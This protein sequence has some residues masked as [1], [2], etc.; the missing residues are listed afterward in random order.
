MTEGSRQRPAPRRSPLL[1]IPSHWIVAV[2]AL[3]VAVFIVGFVAKVA[4]SLR[5][6]QLGVDRALNDMHTPLL[7]RVALLFDGLDKV[8][9]VALYIVVLLVV[10]GL[11]YGWLRAFGAAI[12]A[13][14][15]WLLCLIPKEVVHEIRPPVDSVS[16][17]L[18][19]GRSTLS[20]PSGHVVFAVAFS[21]AV[22]FLVRGTMLRVLL[23]IAGTAFVVVAAW[24]RLYV[25]AHFPTDVVGSVLAGIGGA[26]LV[27]GLWN[28]V[29][30]RALR[31]RSRA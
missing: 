18:H 11:L 13:G 6:A 9:V 26:L 8:P 22:L 15:G 24:A 5:A 1:S 25:A 19:A 2:A 20:Y 3:W 16:H 30:A 27:A 14:A 21:V 10:G 29:V 7:D 23:G 28:V 17:V 4:P 12:A 31:P